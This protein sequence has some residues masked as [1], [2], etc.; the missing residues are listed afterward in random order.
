MYLRGQVATGSRRGKQQPWREAPPYPTAVLPTP[1][2]PLAQ[3]FLGGQCGLGRET[4]LLHL[5]PVCLRA[6]CGPLALGLLC[7]LLASLHVSPTGL[8]MELCLERGPRLTSGSGLPAAEGRAQEPW[9]WRQTTWVLT[10][11]PPL[12]C[13]MTIGCVASLCLSFPV[14]KMERVVGKMR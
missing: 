8:R 4:S 12:R 2:A 13:C 14:C 3:S 9:P 5:T 11:S 6:F 1:S 10:L 7:L